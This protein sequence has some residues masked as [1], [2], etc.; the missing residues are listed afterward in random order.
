MGLVIPETVG[1]SVCDQSRGGYGCGRSDSM[2]S[3]YWGQAELGVPDAELVSETGIVKQT[4]HGWKAKCADLEMHQVGQVAQPQ[5]EKQR[6]NSLLPS[7]RWARRC[8]IRA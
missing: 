7:G 8:C 6:L 2:Q 5:E 4:Y 1:T 3:R